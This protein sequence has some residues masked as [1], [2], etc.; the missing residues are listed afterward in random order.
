M[1]ALDAV[2]TGGVMEPYRNDG[3]LLEIGAISGFAA[4]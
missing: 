1:D 2:E 4:E 3:M